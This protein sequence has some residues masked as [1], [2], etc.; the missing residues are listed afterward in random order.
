MQQQNDGLYRP[1]SEGTLLKDLI[2]KNNSQPKESIKPEK[3]DEVPT[4]INKKKEIASTTAKS[5]HQQD[6]TTESD[7][8]YRRPS[9]YI[10]YIANKQNKLA[11]NQTNPATNCDMWFVV[12]FALLVS[13]YVVMSQP[14]VISFISKWIPTLQ[15]TNDE[16]PLT[17]IMIYGMILGSLF[18][19]TRYV[20]SSKLKIE[21]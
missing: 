3:D 12:E 15:T 14:Y 8:E 4:T 17:G 11:S 1:S 6:S 18:L 20:L 9:T 13:L 10:G 7:T 2:Q 21:H 19:V 16:V 5:V